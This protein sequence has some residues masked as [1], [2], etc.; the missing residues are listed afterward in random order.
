MQRSLTLCV[1]ASPGTLKTK[2]LKRVFNAIQIVM[3]VQTVLRNAMLALTTSI[4]T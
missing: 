1:L 3:F 4:D 2:F